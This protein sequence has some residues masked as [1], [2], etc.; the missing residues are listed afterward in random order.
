MSKASQC[1]EMDIPTLIALS[2]VAW[3]GANI[4]HEIVGHAG[5]AALLGLPI[6]AVSTT[7][8]FAEWDQLPSEVANRLIHAAGT[9]VNLASAA[10]SLLILGYKRNIS[11]ASRLFLW[12]FSTISLII[13]MLNLV[14]TQFL[15]GGDW[16]VVLEGL[17]NQQVWL[18]LVLG[19]GFVVMFLGYVI[20]LKLWM[21][22]LREERRVQLRVTVVPVLT[23]IVVQCLS[24]L[25]SPFASF[26]LPPQQNHLLASVFAFLHFVF[27][28]ILVNAVP[29]P[30]SK[31]PVERISM[32][33][34]P[35]WLAVGLAFLVMFVIILGPGLGPLDQDPRLIGH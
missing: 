3:A 2:V 31:D 6:R 30:R 22:N 16:R 18:A 27:W 12:L 7:T 14:S 11:P 25:R 15:G 28:A 32:P 23:L 24:L 5:S 35:T 34:S 4:L 26:D 1:S 19:G 29:V 13:V 33:R 8:L 17:P 9:V 10:V 21:P 20:P